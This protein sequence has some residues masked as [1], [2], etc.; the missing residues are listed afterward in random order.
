[1]N[2]QGGAIV[3]IKGLEGKPSK[4]LVIIDV[5]K[6]MKD[7]FGGAWKIDEVLNNLVELLT[8]ARAYKTPVIYVQHSESKGEFLRK[9]STWEICDQIKPMA[10]EPCFEKIYCDAFKDTDLA[11]YL[12]EK[13]IT[14]LMLTGLQTEYCIDTTI[15]NVFSRGY[16]LKGVKG[17]H[18]TFDHDALKAETVIEY[19]ES[20]WDKRFLD[21]MTVEEAK[22]WLKSH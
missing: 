8:V 11:E 2:N 21:L 14:D 13:G 18:S 17:G 19:H 10:H 16:S 22:E 12:K 5:Q 6:A 7:C 20:I 15:R 9:T 4:A 3:E 1:M